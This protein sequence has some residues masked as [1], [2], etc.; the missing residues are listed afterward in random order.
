MPP[1]TLQEKK[2]LLPGIKPEPEDI[3]ALEHSQHGQLLR[4]VEK[5]K[6]K[7]AQLLQR[8]FKAR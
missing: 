8:T 7:V 5:A 1:K 6:H 4:R 3:C 2:F